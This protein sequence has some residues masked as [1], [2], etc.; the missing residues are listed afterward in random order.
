MCAQGHEDWLATCQPC[1][2]A[3]PG[4]IVLTLLL[5]FLYV[6]VRARFNARRLRCPSLDVRVHC[7]KTFAG[8]CF[9]PNAHASG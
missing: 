1:K 7:V 8:S 4:Y 2:E 5:V 3:R 9:R 6:L